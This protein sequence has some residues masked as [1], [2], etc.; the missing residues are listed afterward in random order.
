VGE[1]LPD[2]DSFGVGLYEV[3]FLLYRDGLWQNTLQRLQG[4]WRQ[5]EAHA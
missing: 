5:F 3:A 2:A 4:R 1:G